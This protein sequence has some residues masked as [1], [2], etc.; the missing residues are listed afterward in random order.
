[1][2]HQGTSRKDY[3]WRY[4]ASLLRISHIDI[5]NSIPPPIANEVKHIQYF[6]DTVNI[7]VVDSV[8]E[9]AE[10]I[11]ENDNVKI[12]I[13]EYEESYGLYGY[14]VT[15]AETRE[16]VYAFFWSYRSDC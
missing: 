9:E 7:D 2:K 14:G 4:I 1:M 8:Y 16:E 11:F 10:L 5:I 13:E 15:Y 12:Y 6:S 3:I